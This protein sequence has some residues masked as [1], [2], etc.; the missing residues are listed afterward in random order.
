MKTFKTIERLLSDCFFGRKCAVCNKAIPILTDYCPECEL[1]LKRVPDI[2]N[3]SWS[4]L[5][6]IKLSPKVKSYIDGYAAPFYYTLGSEK[7][8]LNYKLKKRGELSDIIATEL[9]Q[10]F[11]KVYSEIYFDFIC[12]VPM[13][14]KDRNVKGFD[15][16]ELLSEKLAEIR[17]IEYL[18]ALYQIKDKLPQHTLSATMR[19]NNVKN[20]YSIIENV[21][22]TGKTILLI[23]DICTTGASLNEAAKTLKKGGAK[24]VYCLAVCVSARA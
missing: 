4:K 20:I 6:N 21:S 2:L 5:S 18:P 22:V 24:R 17:G 15:H 1:T 23:D 12:A 13:L 8:I 16:T 14:K 3:S 7:L 19:R 11:E 10:V 9:D